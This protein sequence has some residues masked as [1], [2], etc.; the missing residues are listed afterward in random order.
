[1]VIKPNRGTNESAQIKDLKKNLGQSKVSG[2]DK[3]DFFKLLAEPEVSK[4]TITKIQKAI[5]ASVADS[6]PESKPQPAKEEPK[7]EPESEFEKL[8]KTKDFKKFIKMQVVIGQLDEDT[9]IEELSDDDFRKI[10]TEY[11]GWVNAGRPKPQLTKEAKGK[12][13]KILS[14]TRRKHIGK[15]YLTYVVEGDDVAIGVKYELTYAQV[16]Q[17][18]G[19]FITDTDIVVKR[20]PR[21]T[22]KYT[23]ESAK[24]L[25]ERC[26]KEAVNPKFYLALQGRVI[27]VQSTDNFT[28]DFDELMAKAMKSEVI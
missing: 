9:I 4:K 8:S 28:K 22:I 20:E 27:S 21:Y 11:H 7:E 3:K 15:Q 10:I 13:E 24:K 5:K 12:M 26:L 17:E 6:G 1:M 16:E 14:V 25:M 18:D 19:T 2:A 23:T